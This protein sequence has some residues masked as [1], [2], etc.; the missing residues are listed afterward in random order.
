MVCVLFAAFAV[1]PE[2]KFFFGVLF[3][4]YRD[5]VLAFANLTNESYSDA[6]FFFG[7]EGIID[8]RLKGIKQEAI[9]LYY[10]RLSSN[11]L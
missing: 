1:F 9:Q 10:P 7:H 5:I 4:F 3:I 6:F 8:D 11:I 2:K